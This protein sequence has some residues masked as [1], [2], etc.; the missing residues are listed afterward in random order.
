MNVPECRRLRLVLGD[1][2]NELHDWFSDTCPDSLYV[3]AE[4]RQEAT[5]TRHH[6]QKMAAFFAAMRSFADRLEALGHR[7]LFLELD[8]TAGYEDLPAL[9]EALIRHSGA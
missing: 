5:Y 4:L 3:L 6:V 8:D 2:L 9:L 1:Q 7:V